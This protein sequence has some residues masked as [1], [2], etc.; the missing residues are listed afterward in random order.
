MADAM[1]EAQG[2]DDEEEEEV[3][4][5]EE[6]AA[7]TIALPDGA[8]LRKTVMRVGNYA[9]PPRAGDGCVITYRE[10]RGE[11][12]PSDEESHGVDAGA[13]DGTVEHARVRVMLAPTTPANPEVGQEHSAAAAAAATASSRLEPHSPDRPGQGLTLVHFSAQLERFLWDRWCA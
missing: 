7:V 9:P 11:P 5:D 3:L 4:A 6:A 12:E 2:T 13:G 1:A 8:T 10:R